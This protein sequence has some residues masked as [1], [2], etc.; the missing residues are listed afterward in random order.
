MYK[1]LR[2]FKLEELFLLGFYCFCF[3]LIQQQ[4]IC[5]RSW[6]SQFQSTKMPMIYLLLSFRE[7]AAVAGSEYLTS[8][9]KGKPRWSLRV[10]AKHCKPACPPAPQIPRWESC[11]SMPQHTLT[12][13]ETTSSDLSLHVHEQPIEETPAPLWAGTCYESPG[14]EARCICNSEGITCVAVTLGKLQFVLLHA[15]FVIIPRRAGG[16]R[17]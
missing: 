16:G 12:G 3:V 8:Q 14:K 13:T 15:S 2:K 6:R 11:E 17:D 9:G 10:P 5:R 1:E 7:R 4:N